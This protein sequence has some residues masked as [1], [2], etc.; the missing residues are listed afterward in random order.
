MAFVN[1]LNAVFPGMGNP[2]QND[3]LLL[4]QNIALSTTGQQTNSLTGI[5]PTLSKGYVRVKVFAAGGTAPTLLNLIVN[6]TDGTTFVNVGFFAPVVAIAPAFSLVA[7]GT[8]IG[9]S[10][11]AITTGT[12]I[13]T[14]V[15]N[16][17]TPAMV[18]SAISVTTAGAGATTLYTT[19]LSYQSAGQVTLAVNAG[20]TATVGVMT[21]T[22][23]YGNGGTNTALAGI[24]FLIPFEVDINVNQVSVLTTLGGTTPTA[25]MDLEVA[26]TI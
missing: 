3:T 7:G 24:D 18:G 2:V 26:G 5:T 13:L 12:A 17:F 20:A 11:G 4:K 16:P 22:S 10:N 6:V 23:S 1:R 19:I 14:S 9:A 8:V 25:Q 21:L 15:S